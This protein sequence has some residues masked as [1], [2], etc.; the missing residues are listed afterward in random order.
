MN[1]SG[2]ETQNEIA[3]LEHVP[4]SA[5]HTFQARLVTDAPVSVLDDLVSDDLSG[6]SRNRRFMRSSKHRSLL[7]GPHRRTRNQIPSAT[8]WCANNDAVETS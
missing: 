5:M 6:H 7:R 3:G 8:L 1:I 2:T 4:Y